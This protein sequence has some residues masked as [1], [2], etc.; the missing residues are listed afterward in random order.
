MF[1]IVFPSSSQWEDFGEQ[2]VIRNRVCHI[3]SEEADS[4]SNRTQPRD[5]VRLI[6]RSI[7]FDWLHR[8]VNRLLTTFVNFVDT[9]QK[10]PTDF[11]AL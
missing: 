2:D 7:Y 4:H 8:L 11:S 3:V 5:W 9:S 10:K 6:E 1:S